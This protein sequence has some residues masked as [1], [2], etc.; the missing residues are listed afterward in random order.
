MKE[1]YVIEADIVGFGRRVYL[2]EVWVDFVNN[3]NRLFDALSN[4]K[5]FDPYC[6]FTANLAKAAKFDEDVVKDYS[7]LRGLKE[8]FRSEFFYA[9]FAEKTGDVDQD[10]EDYLVVV[11]AD[12]ALSGDQKKVAIE[13]VDP[14]EAF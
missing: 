12:A 5:D 1:L 6:V 7:E 14:F 10:I 3:P 9:I 11:P 4:D 8:P 13:D 2:N